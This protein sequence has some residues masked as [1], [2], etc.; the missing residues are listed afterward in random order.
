MMKRNTPSP[1]GP[2]RYRGI[3]V[4]DFDGTLRPADGRIAEE[5]LDALARLGAEGY[6]RVIATGRSLYSLSRA[7]DTGFPV[8][9]VIFS[10]GTGIQ[11]FE[12]Q[13]IINRHSLGPAEILGVWN[14]LRD[15]DMDFMLHEA[16]PDNHR[17]IYRRSGRVNGDFDR[18]LEVYTGC[19]RALESAPD[20]SEATQFVVINPGSGALNRHRRIE[21]KL[22]GLNVVRTTSPLDGRAVWT[23]ILPAGASKGRAA[24]R[25]A[26]C[27]GV[28]EGPSIA[29]GNDFND[30]DLLEWGR[31]SYVVA[32][33][34]GRLREEFTP[35]VSKAGGGALCES[36][37]LALGL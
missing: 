15:M 2:G 23:E 29:V 16:I 21:K 37:R 22:P 5:D 35:L 9:Y 30:R 14:L 3:V 33:A 31:K 27:L 8:D 7:I 26:E 18:R 32:D 12:N 6:A 17:F 11:D 13:R 10:S 28:A 25:L 20:L 36:I 24:S 34:P 4:T 1:P 19:H